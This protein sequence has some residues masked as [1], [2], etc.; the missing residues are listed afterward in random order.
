MDQKKKKSFITAD[1]LEAGKK[2][3]NLTLETGTITKLLV[4][5]SKLYPN[6]NPTTVATILLCQN[7]DKHY[8]QFRDSKELPGQMHLFNKDQK[9]PKKGKTK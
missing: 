5:G 2:R 8:L 1:D 6:T 4:I 3:I 9:K 7:I